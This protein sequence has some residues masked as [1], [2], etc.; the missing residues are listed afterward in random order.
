MYFPSFL[1]EK[2]SEKVLLVG[3]SGKDAPKLGLWEKKWFCSPSCQRSCVLYQSAHLFLF[4]FPGVAFS[5]LINWCSSV[6]DQQRA[7]ASVCDL[8]WVVPWWCCF[9]G[10]TLFGCTLF[11]HLQSSLYRYLKA[12]RE[13]ETYL[14][15]WWHLQSG[16]GF[17]TL[18]KNFLCSNQ[19]Q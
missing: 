9:V 16:G 18:C 1:H 2:G 14:V 8:L 17:E 15:Q 6:T 12:G 11:F 10:Y 7:C 4:V 13:M 5:F 19:Y 3:H